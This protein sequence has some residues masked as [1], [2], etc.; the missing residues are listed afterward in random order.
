VYDVKVRSGLN[1]P[2]TVIGGGLLWM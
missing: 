2:Q 1:W